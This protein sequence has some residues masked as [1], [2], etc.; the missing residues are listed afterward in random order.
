MNSDPE[1]QFHSPLTRKL[2]GVFTS[3]VFI[4][5]LTAIMLGTIAWAITKWQ[6]VIS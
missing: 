1:Q 2:M 6:E 3:A 4:I 5:F